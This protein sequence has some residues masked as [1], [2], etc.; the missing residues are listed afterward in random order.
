[1]D[2]VETMAYVGKTPW[3]GLGTYLGEDDVTAAR[4]MRAAGLDWAVEKAKLQTTDG[5]DVPGHFAIRRVTDGRMFGV[6]GKKYHPF[7]NADAFEFLDEVLGDF[8]ARFHTAGALLDGR[9]V[10]AL[11]RMSGDMAVKRL[12]G[13]EDVHQRFLLV[14]NSHDGQSSIRVAFTDVRVVC[15]NTLSAALGTAPNTFSIRHTASAKAKVAEARAALGVAASY[16]DHLHEVEQELARERMRAAEFHSFAEQLMLDVEV[17]VAAAKEKLGDLQKRRHTED[18]QT[19]DRLF[20]HGK[21]NTGESKLDALNAV[22]EFVDHHK[23]VK[24]KD[25]VRKAKR[26]ASA[27]YGDGLELKQRALRRLT[28]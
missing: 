10:W 8:G 5:A 7:Q 21:G 17:E 16:F 6:V 22:T 12:D 28:R 13:K 27:W 15:W 23:R 2:A 19:L 20:S 25:E 3:H 11:V 4:M 1:M 24:A 18:V 9:L 26:L 14:S